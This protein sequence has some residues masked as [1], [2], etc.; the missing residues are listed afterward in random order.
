MGWV[1]L[2]IMIPFKSALHP[3]KIGNKLSYYLQH[4]IFI[5]YPNKTFKIQQTYKS[6]RGKQVCYEL[7]YDSI[8]IQT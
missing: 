7:F 6:M 8:T 5:G 3:N 2:I 1:V 4:L